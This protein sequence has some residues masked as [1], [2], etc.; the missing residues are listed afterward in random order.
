[1]TSYDN[2]AYNNTVASLAPAKLCVVDVVEK[3]SNSYDNLY[4]ESTN[5]VL[6]VE[7]IKSKILS[8]Y[9]NMTP[10][11]IVFD[12]LKINKEEADKIL[13]LLPNSLKDIVNQT[14]EEEAKIVRLY[15]K[16]V[17]TA[18]QITKNLINQ[19]ECQTEQMQE[20]INSLT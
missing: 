13:D 19:I 6:T 11:D 10:K 16:D 1:M 9:N 2:S 4:P 7:K 8:N 20:M 15:R 14:A 5:D 3:M 18:R 17:Q 12:L